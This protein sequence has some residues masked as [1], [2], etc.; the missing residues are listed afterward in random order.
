MGITIATTRVAC[1]TTTGNQ[2]IT[3]TDLGGLTP[4]AAFFIVTRAVTDGTP[5][6]HAILGLGAATATDE[7]WACVVRSENAQGTTDTRRRATSDECVM[8]LNTADANVDGEADFGAF[9]TNGVR[10]IWGNAPTSGYLLTVVLYA[11]TDLSAKALHFAVAAVQDATVDVNTVGSEPDAL[12]TAYIAYDFDDTTQTNAILSHGIVTNTSPI[13]QH[14]WGIRYKYSQATSQSLAHIYDHYGATQVNTGTGAAYR[15]FEFS[16]FDAQG[17]SCTTRLT[18]GTGDIGCL[19][20]AFGGAVSFK[21]GIIDS[22]TANGSQ[23]ITDPS[24]TP[25][26]VHIGLTQMQAVDTGYTTD[27]AGSI[28]ISVFDADD[29]HCNSIQDEDAQGTSDTQSLSD[30]TAINLPDDD[31]TAGWVA[32]FTSFDA[33]GWTWNF[34]QSHGTA[35]KWW[36]LAIEE[37]TAVTTAALPIISGEAIHSLIFGGVIVR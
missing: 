14:A 32:S 23:S 1:N 4:K 33:N 7:R 22:P 34:T 27:V 3:T 15:G 17:F 19:A 35:V 16:A 31:S 36:Y 18:T 2:D 5:A 37:E 9:I 12:L 26:H 25:Q 24:F 30:N 13:I 20:L 10:I 11:G 6:N 8:I 21:A 29:E 28:G